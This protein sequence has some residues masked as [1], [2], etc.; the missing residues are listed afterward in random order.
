M[1]KIK[2]MTNKEIVLGYKNFW[3]KKLIAATIDLQLAELQDPEATDIDVD[4]EPIKYGDKVINL[5]KNIKKAKCFIGITQDLLKL[6]KQG[7]LS[8]LWSKEALEIDET[9]GNK[10]N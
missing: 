3:L 6:E 9:K 8:E 4:G 5:K 1:P 2:E 10:E 7:K